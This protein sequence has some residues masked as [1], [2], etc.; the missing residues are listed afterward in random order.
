LKQLIGTVATAI[1]VVNRAASNVRNMA[2][3]RD[4]IQLIVR[5]PAM[6]PEGDM[7]VDSQIITDPYSGISFD[8]RLYKGYGV[9]TLEIHLAWGFHTC[10]I[11][12]YYFQEKLFYLVVSSK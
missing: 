9:N 2:F 1:T 5:A 6:P 4:A 3:D 7:A 10:H 11:P 12:L 8:A